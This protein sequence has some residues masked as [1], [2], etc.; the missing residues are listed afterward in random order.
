MFLT[1]YYVTLGLLLA[2]CAIYQYFNFNALSDKTPEFL[3]FQKR[4]L[5]VYYIVMFSDWLQGPYTYALYSDYGFDRETIA[6][7]FIVGYGSSAL[8]GTFIGSV[9]DIYGRKKF[10]VLFGIIYSL[11]CFVKLYNNF[12]LLFIGRVLGG[13]AT[14][15]LF[16]VFE[17]WMV[18]QHHANKF[19]DE[20]ISDTFGLATLGNGF[21]A[22]GAGMVASYLTPQ[23][24]TVSPFVLSMVC[25]I[26]SIFV[27]SFLWSENYGDAKLDMNVLFLNSFSAIKNDYRIL[28]L[29][30]VQSLF[31][32]SMYVFVFLWTPVLE[33]DV[34]EFQD[35]S[36]GMHGMI[37]SAFMVCTMA[38][39]SIFS[40][41]IKRT[42]PENLAIG[43]YITAAISLFSVGI[44]IKFLGDGK[45]YIIYAAFL[46][47]E[48][49]VGVYYPIMG[50]LKSSYIPEESRSAVM[51]LFRLPL[52][53]LVVLVLKW[54]NMFNN[55]SLFF[56]ITSWLGIASI[57]LY[58]GVASKR[59]NQL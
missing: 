47:F 34:P 53:I 35:K 5:V 48:T 51:N 42:L 9:A 49:C 18:S 24:G 29:G 4:Y 56:I 40:Y 28:A 46:V 17:A 3:V 7:L 44:S 1:F 10:A 22:V 54:I 25:L 26:I 11:S 2:Y 30:L 12:F 37:F 13:I 19:D 23:F 20:W 27:V 8:F 33:S 32:A 21:V 57:I 6:T 15:L 41:F 59:P 14:S 55:D 39:S 31:E 38:G 36:L 58:L 43:C 16:S 52:N 50:T 45:E